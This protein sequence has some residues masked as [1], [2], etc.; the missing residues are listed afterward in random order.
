MAAPM[1]NWFP[2]HMCGWKNCAAH[3]PNDV[4]PNRG[5]LA[6]HV[7]NVVH[8]FDQVEHTIIPVFSQGDMMI[9]WQEALPPRVEDAANR[10]DLT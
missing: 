1:W 2:L 4:T 3:V 9:A 6:A 5:T 7:Q 10:R 8:P